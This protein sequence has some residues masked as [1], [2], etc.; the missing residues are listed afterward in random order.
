LIDLPQHGKYVFRIAGVQIA[1]RFISQNH[2]RLV[3]QG[4]G[5]RRPLLF[6]AG[7]GIGPIIA[8]VAQPD[9]SSKSS[10]LFFTVGVA[11]PA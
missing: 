7:D 9:R 1:G 5:N 11:R 2:A 6:P 3:D 8:A 10:A 4:T